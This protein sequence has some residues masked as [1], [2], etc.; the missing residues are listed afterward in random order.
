MTTARHQLDLAMSEE[1]LQAQILQLAKLEGW[2]RHHTRPAR[3]QD[4][5]WRTPL[6][7]DKGYPDLTLAHPDGLVVIA[8][9]KTQ[10]GKPTVEQDVWLD[11]LNGAELY[12]AC[13]RP[14]DWDFIEQLLRMRLT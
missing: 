7:G 9:L 12:S 11:A 8:E 2:L 14:S 13:W 6:Q 1:D 4:G 5:G 10:R 3:T